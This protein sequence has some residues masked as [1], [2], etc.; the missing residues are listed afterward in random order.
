MSI[1]LSKITDHQ[2]EEAFDAPN[3]DS[4]SSHVEELDEDDAKFKRN[5]VLKMKKYFQDAQLSKKL[6]QVEQSDIDSLSLDELEDRY[7]KVKLALSND[8]STGIVGFGYGYGCTLLENLS[9]TPYSPISLD[10]MTGTLMKNEQV[11]DLLAELNVEYSNFE[12]VTRPEQRLLYIT[13]FTA[14]S[15]GMSNMNKATQLQAP[16]EIHPKQ[17]QSQP[18]R[19]IIDQSKYNDL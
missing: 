12:S 18:G 15:V 19:V 13:A 3:Y 8:N 17:Q 2:E 5:L 10:G 11:L 1:D 4:N 7:H 9:K 6:A 16:L 14:L